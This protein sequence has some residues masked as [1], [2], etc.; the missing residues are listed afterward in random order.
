MVSAMR[1]GRLLLAGLCLSTQVIHTST[2][3]RTRACSNTCIH[4]DT[5]TRA[6][7]HALCST[8][9]CAHTHVFML[10]H[11]HAHTNMCAHMYCGHS[12]R[13]MYKVQY[14]LSM[15]TPRCAHTHA[16]IHEHSH[17]HTCVYIYAQTYTCVTPCSPNAIPT[18]CS[19]PVPTLSPCPYH[20]SSPCCALTLSQPSFHTAPYGV[21]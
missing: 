15:H 10:I 1:E 18:H 12:H 8:L 17:A 16:C 13:C 11:A 6:C 4:I 5:D 7:V 14:T 2:Y 3:K 21:P 9:T 19:H 20:S